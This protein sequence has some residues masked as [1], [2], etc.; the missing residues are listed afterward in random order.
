MDLKPSSFILDASQQEPLQPKVW[1]QKRWI[2]STTL[3][4]CWFY[5][6][7]PL[8]PKTTGFYGESNLESQNTS[9][10]WSKTQGGN[11]NLPPFS[12]NVGFQVDFKPPIWLKYVKY[13]VS[14]NC[15]NHELHRIY[16]RHMSLCNDVGPSCDVAIHQ[17]PILQIGP[18][19][20]TQRHFP[21]VLLTLVPAAVGGG[22]PPRNPCGNRWVEETFSP[23]SRKNMKF[24]GLPSDDVYKQDINK[25]WKWQTTCFNLP[26]EWT[27]SLN[28]SPMLQLFNQKKRGI[29]TVDFTQIR[30]I[31]VIFDP[32][33]TNFTAQFLSLQHF[34]PHRSHHL[35]LGFR[36]ASNL[37]TKIGF[38]LGKDL[39]TS[40]TSRPNW[41]TSIDKMH[42]GN[43]NKLHGRALSAN[44]K[45]KRNWPFRTKSLP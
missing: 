27:P 1:G 31:W 40:T 15:Q 35:V 26:G 28:F 24:L 16:C 20:S 13:I 41:P 22:S 43:P 29:N 30:W 11:R 7:K 6:L 36:A 33:H 14:P 3:S 10:Q 34:E 21:T 38:P 45:Q 9:K 37:S 5:H 25:P 4:F 32:N 23:Q 2:S 12:N 18:G 44:R 17:G 19:F 8:A 39:K 42:S